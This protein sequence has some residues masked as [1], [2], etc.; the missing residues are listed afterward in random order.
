VTKSLSIIARNASEAAY[1][2][3]W[4]GL[5]GA[6]VPSLGVT[7][8]TLRDVSGRKHHGTLTNM[9]PAT[10]WQASGGWS[11]EFAG[12]DTAGGNASQNRV[13]L[14]RDYGVD[15][16]TFSAWVRPKTLS[17]RGIC[18]SAT[19]YT[20]PRFA[21]TLLTTGQ[22]EVYRGGNAWSTATLTT[23]RWQHISVASDGVTTTFYLDG[24]FSNS[25]SQSISQP[26]QTQFMLG[27][28]YWGAFDGY[29][30]DV[31]IHNRVI[32]SRENKL[33]ATRRGIAFHRKR[34]RVYSIPA[35]PAFKAAWATRATTI[36]GVL[37]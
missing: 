8:E 35:G 33:L 7:G 21:I 9:D 11:L 6:W 4:Q 34:R 1:P 16:L 25:A 30:D 36:A 3:L 23:G 20:R 19:V 29:M 37:Q 14:P 22:L 17:K 27:N 32:T 31:L 28:N 12:T 2:H 5:A 26:L 15:I 10:D 18:S 24:E 13:A